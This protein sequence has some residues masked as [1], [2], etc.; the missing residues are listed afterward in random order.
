MTEKELKDN[1]LA[2]IKVRELQPNTIGQYTYLF[3][4]FL[5]YCKNNNINPEEITREQILFYL[6]G[7]KS[8]S[9][10]R[11]MKGTIGNFC[12]FV[13][14][15]GFLMYGI[16]NPSRHYDVPDYFSTY[17]L[18]QIFNSIKNIKQRT[19]MKIE[20]ACALR[21]NEACQIK[22]TDFIKR[23]DF[24]LQ[25]NVYDLRVH[26]KGGNFN[27]IPVPTETINEISAY[28]KTLKEKE[29]QSEYLFVGQFKSS[30]SPRSVQKRLRKAMNDLRIVKYGNH[31]THFLRISRITHYL[32]SGVE[33]SQVARFARHKNISTTQRHYNGITTSDLR[34]VFS[35]ADKFLHD[36]LQIEKA[37]H[38]KRLTA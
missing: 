19:L 31:N 23:W 36:N 29:C 5:W 30:Y 24:N 26:G 35:K 8:E 25:K 17:E 32:L 37:Q 13:L 28:Y 20:Y 16:P 4:S 1:F 7:I 34:V 2:V 15:K 38:Q 18:D 11:Q 3:N 6:S 9:T 12:E 14:M 22:K 33:I 27:L 10:R 21:V